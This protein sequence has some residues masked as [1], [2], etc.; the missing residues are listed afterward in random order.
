[1]VKK[2][3]RIYTL[4]QMGIKIYP[5]NERHMCPM[6]YQWQCAGSFVRW[7]VAW[8]GDGGGEYPQYGR[9]IK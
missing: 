3:E 4:T 7:L 1:M 2:D 6:Y 9:L 5:Y 8:H